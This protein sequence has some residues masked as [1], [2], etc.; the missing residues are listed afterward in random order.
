[1]SSIPPPL[2]REHAKTATK[3]DAKHLDAP[4]SGGTK[5]AVQGTLAIM[6]GGQSQTFELARTV[7]E[8]MG[9]PVLVGPSGS[10]QLAKL[11]NQA[12]VGISIG[13]IAE[14]L[15]F[16]AAAGADPTKVKEA[17][18]GGFAD[19]EILGQHGQRML[20]RSFIPGGPIWAQVKDLKTL[21]ACAEALHIKLPLVD[22][23]T[24]LFDSCLATGLGKY[25]HSALLL[26]LERRNPGSRLG[27]LPDKTPE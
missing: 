20:E 4:V 19:S 7:F 5:G 10:G 9:R 14:A 25:D 27:K 2:A 26:E 24:E 23:V 12:I 22:A 11:A 15:L 8:V 18:A 3:F 16:V 13:A 6:V 21:T 1:M 17:F